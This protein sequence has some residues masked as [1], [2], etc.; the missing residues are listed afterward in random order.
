MICHNKVCSKIFV[1]YM[2]AK[3]KLAIKFENPCAWYFIT[4]RITL[5]LIHI[6]DENTFCHGQAGLLEIDDIQSCQKAASKI[7]HQEPNTTFYGA[8]SRHT[9][10]R[11]HWPRGCF[12]STNTERVYFNKHYIGHTHPAARP[13]CIRNSGIQNK[14]SHCITLIPILLICLV[15]ISL[16]LQS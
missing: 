5:G 1:S 16:S 4:L 7:I 14:S 12:I 6:A 15:Y 8:M 9:S 3:R 11:N 13:L 2:L 10:D